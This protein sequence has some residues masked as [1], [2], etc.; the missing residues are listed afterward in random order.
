MVR[1]PARWRVAVLPDRSIPKKRPLLTWWSHR[2]FCGGGRASDGFGGEYRGYF[3]VRIPK[4]LA[5]TGFDET[6]EERPS[7]HVAI[8]CPQTLP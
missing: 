6:I 5:A 3:R 7:R 1:G 8:S 4:Q 2:K